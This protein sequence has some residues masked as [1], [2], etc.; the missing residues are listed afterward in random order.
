M[1]LWH[2]VVR[3][4][5]FGPSKRPAAE[6]LY[7]RSTS[8]PSETNLNEASSS[9]RVN[10]SNYVTRVAA[11]SEPHG[12]SG[13]ISLT[14]SRPQTS[15]AANARYSNQPSVQKQHHQPP[16]YAPESI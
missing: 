10:A 11:P 7:H 14:N 13:A 4:L 6:T 16:V 1:E 5:K 12:F 9:N 15:T 2:E 3:I 8:Q